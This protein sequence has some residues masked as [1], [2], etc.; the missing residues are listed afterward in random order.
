MNNNINKYLAEHETTLKS[1]GITSSDI[2]MK[3]DTEDNSSEFDWTASVLNNM[4]GQFGTLPVDY[5]KHLATNGELPNKMV[6]VGI[7][8]SSPAH[9]L[10]GYTFYADWQNYSG[11]DQG[12]AI[13]ADIFGIGLGY[14]GGVLTGGPVGAVIG[15]GIGGVIGDRIADYM[16]SVGTTPKP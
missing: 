13:G 4:A 2:P 15:G 11:K 1:L 5:A 3:K 10:E 6:I 8:G 14:G 9:L 7:F 16:K 12:I